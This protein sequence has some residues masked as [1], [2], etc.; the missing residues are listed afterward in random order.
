MKMIVQYTD[1]AQVRQ[2]VVANDAIAS[3]MIADLVRAGLGADAFATNRHADKYDIGWLSMDYPPID[4]Q[5]KC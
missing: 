3:Q 2:R 4:L 5:K 1:G